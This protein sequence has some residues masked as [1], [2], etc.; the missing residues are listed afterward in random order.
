MSEEEMRE[1][2]GDENYDEWQRKRGQSISQWHKN[3]PEESQRLVENYVES[4][5]KVGETEIEKRVREYLENQDLNFEQE[6]YLQIRDNRWVVDFLIERALYVMIDGC[7][8]HSC[9]ACNY[10]VDSPKQ[11]RNRKVDKLF[12]QVMSAESKE[13]LRIWGHEVKEGR[14]GRV[15]SKRLRTLE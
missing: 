2:I 3:N 14:H 4:A 15:I 12:N 1:K 13:F 7:Y 10:E 8:W 6:H 9:P 11:R 5:A